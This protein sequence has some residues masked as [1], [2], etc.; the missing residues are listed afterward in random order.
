MVKKMSRHARFVLF[1]WSLLIGLCL[2]HTAHAEMRIAVVDTQWS[3]MQTEDGARAQSTL[4]KFFYSRQ[5]ELD[6]RQK[7][8]Q[9]EREYISKQ[10]RLLSKAAFQRRTEHWQKQMLEVQ[11]LFVQYNKELQKKQLELTQ[12]ILQKLFAVIRRIAQN[13][14]YDIVVDKSAVPFARNDLNLSDMVVQMYNSGGVPADSAEPKD[15]PKPPP[16]GT[17]APD[18]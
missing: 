3:V 11:T 14:G 2:P 4:K 5:S 16:D 7:Q 1:A 8:L 15:G 10:S 13:R 6:R 17:P 12:P 9:Q 18:K